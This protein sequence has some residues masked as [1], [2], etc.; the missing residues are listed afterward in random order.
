MPAAELSAP[1]GSWIRIGDTEI[2]PGAA[3]GS[4]DTE[5]LSAAWS[6]TFATD[7]EPC[8][9]LPADWLYSAP[10][11]KTKFV[12]PVPLPT[13]T[14]GSNSTTRSRSSSPAGPG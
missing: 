8:K 9:Y 3:E 5:A 1:P 11:P 4:V 7:A 6:L 13:S 10:L 12:A 14:A 2:G